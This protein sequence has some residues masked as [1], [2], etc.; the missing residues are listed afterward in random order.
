MSI[1]VT[2]VHVN[3]Y[4]AGVSGGRLVYQERNLAYTDPAEP[5]CEVT[6]IPVEDI[7]RVDTGT[8]L[9]L[10]GFRGLALFYLLFAV[11]ATYRAVLFLAD[12]A[13]L[14]VVSGGTYVI[15]IF[16]WYGVANFATQEVGAVRILTVETVETEYTFL[17]DGQTERFGQIASQLGGNQT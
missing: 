2:D 15:A 9:S 17:T 11:V 5:E 12:G 8:D 16:C 14:T 6:T 13:E 4:D 7:T 1:D 10:T 3:E